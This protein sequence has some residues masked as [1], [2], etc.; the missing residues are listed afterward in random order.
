M[1][2]GPLSETHSLTAIQDIPSTFMEP[3]VLLPCS[4]QP[5]TCPYL[6]P[7]QASPCL[8]VL[9]LKYQLQCHPTI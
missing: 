9:F 7:H 5:A 8:T 1:K 6:K 3:K 4:Q 2:L